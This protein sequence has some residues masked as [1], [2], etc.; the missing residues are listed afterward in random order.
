MR[1]GQSGDGDGDVAVLVEAGEE[2]FEFAQSGF[3]DLLD[4]G[5]EVRAAALSHEAGELT[6]Q[7]TRAVISGRSAVISSSGRNG[8][9]ASRRCE[10]GSSW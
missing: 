7:L 6:D 9:W 1:Q 3:A 2:G 5:V 8:Y 10:S 4:P